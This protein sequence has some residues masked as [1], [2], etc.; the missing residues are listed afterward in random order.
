M[1]SRWVGG[2]NCTS[3]KAVTLKCTSLKGLL[4]DI[5]FGL[6][7]FRIDYIEYK[8]FLIL[9]IIFGLSFFSKNVL[10]HDFLKLLFTSLTQFLTH[11][12][13]YWCNMQFGLNKIFV[14]QLH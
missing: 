7:R 13:D 4:L 8:L 3:N 9:K 14:A 1:V 10:V 2:Q 12:L 5:D 6:F 11:L